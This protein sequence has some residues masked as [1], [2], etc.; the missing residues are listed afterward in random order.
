MTSRLTE[1]FVASFV[2]GSHFITYRDPWDHHRLAPVLWW[3]NAVRWAMVG[4]VLRHRDKWI[5]ISRL[6]R[7]NLPFMMFFGCFFLF[8]HMKKLTIQTNIQY[9]CLLILT[10]NSHRQSD[11]QI[12]AIWAVQGT[13][14]SVWPVSAW[15][16]VCTV[17]QSLGKCI[18]PPSPNLIA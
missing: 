1:E 12:F 4:Y 5:Q 16:R 15:T 9:A 6:L 7:M 2:K 11:I 10:T 8:Y 17:R 18:P 13:L 14:W 3:Y